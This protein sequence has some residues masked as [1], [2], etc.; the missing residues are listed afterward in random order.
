MSQKE[1]KKEVHLT[2]KERKI[3]LRYVTECK[4]DGV[5]EEDLNHLMKKLNKN[6]IFHFYTEKE[7]KFIKDNYLI[8]E[9][10]EVTRMFNEY[11][12]ENVSYYSIR[13]VIK[14]YNLK[15]DKNKQHDFGKETRGKKITEF[16]SAES[17]EK[18]KATQF[19]KGQKAHNAYPVGYERPN[20]D[21]FIEVKIS[22][23][24]G[25]NKKKSVWKLKHHLI[26][27]NANG[28]MPA[29]HKIIF[30]DGDNRNFN[31]DNLILIS[32]SEFMS[33]KKYGLRYTDSKEAAESGIL[34]TKILRKVNGVRG[35]GSKEHA[36]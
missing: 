4:I 20:K 9:A 11:F 33:M 13:G 21:D 15:C 3:V 18:T 22:S 32:N 30:A 5:S 36:S 25:Q 2:E 35:D 34:M 17:I 26:W 28:Q 24:I 14:R 16:M 8:Y 12:N 19:K 27:E 1:V 31:I 7:L 23:P 10:K 29:N 6:P